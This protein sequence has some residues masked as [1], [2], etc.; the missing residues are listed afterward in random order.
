[1]P[2]VLAL[3][4]GAWRFSTKQ[5]AV[6]PIAFWLVFFPLVIAFFNVLPSLFILAQALMILWG[7]VALLVV[8]K[9][10]LQTKAGRSRTSLRT[11][12]L[13][14]RRYIIPSALTGLLFAGLSLLRALLLIVPGILYIVRTS[15]FPIVI[16]AEGIEYRAALMRSQK[17]VRGRTLQVFLTLLSLGIV[18]IGPAF[19]VRF[20]LT[21]ALP[22][23]EVETIIIACTTALLTTI[24]LVLFTF[25][26]ILY[27]V[28][29]LPS[30]KVQ[31][32]SK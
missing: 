17:I 26:M 8:G 25:A 7:E 2:S 3:I 12:V 23:L 22:T 27:Y 24:G 20:F 10:L 15:F 18:L 5:P 30:N 21:S 14:A 19:L 32:H 11:T 6:L 1:M 16:V 29:L 9:R 28:E 4:G 31:V 13:Q